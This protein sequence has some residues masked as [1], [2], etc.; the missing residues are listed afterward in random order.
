[1]SPCHVTFLR[2]CI[3]SAIW[4]SSGTS[5]WIDLGNALVAPLNTRCVDPNVH[6]CGKYSITWVGDKSFLVQVKGRRENN[7]VCRI[8]WGFRGLRWAFVRLLCKYAC[9]SIFI[10]I[11]IWGCRGVWWVW[12]MIMFR[13]FGRMCTRSKEKRPFLICWII[14]SHMKYM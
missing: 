2:Q 9:G 4:K 1:M 3:S 10:C 5:R 14:R 11:L 6:V 8:V 7:V 13:I 12:G